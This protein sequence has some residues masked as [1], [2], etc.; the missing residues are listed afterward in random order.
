MK[1]NE[2]IRRRKAK[3]RGRWRKNRLENTGTTKASAELFKV[4]G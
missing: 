1:Q 2:T 4:V 3:R